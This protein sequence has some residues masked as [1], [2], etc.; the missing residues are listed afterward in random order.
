MDASSRYQALADTSIFAAVSA[1]VNHFR[2]FSSSCPKI[3]LAS[4]ARNRAVALVD[5]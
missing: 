2:T 5:G 3:G 1:V 4:C